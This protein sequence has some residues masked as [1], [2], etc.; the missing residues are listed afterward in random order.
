MH[1]TLKIKVIRM[2]KAPV[3]DD[4]I[5]NF[6]TRPQININ[7]SPNGKDIVIPQAGQ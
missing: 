4:E 1:H 5:E 3:E 7:V 6:D 2:E